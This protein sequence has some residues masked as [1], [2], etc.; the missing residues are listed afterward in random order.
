MQNFF[1]LAE[2]PKSIWKTIRSLL[3]YN[4]SQDTHKN[5]KIGMAT[6]LNFP[7]GIFIKFLLSSKK[8]SFNTVS[9]RKKSFIFSAEEIPP[10]LQVYTDKGIWRCFLD[11]QAP[12]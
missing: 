1:L 9:W 8:Q 6:Y 5:K 12:F 10:G 11:I 2:E 4:I 7:Q 3:T